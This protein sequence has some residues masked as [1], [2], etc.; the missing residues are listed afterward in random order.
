M[1]LSCLNKVQ[2]QPAAMVKW[3]LLRDDFSVCQEEIGVTSRIYSRLEGLLDWIVWLGSTDERFGWGFSG[4]E[5]TLTPSLPPFNGGLNSPYFV[6]H[7]YRS[8]YI[9]LPVSR[10][11]KILSLTFCLPADGSK[12]CVS[13]HSTLSGAA[14]FW[15]YWMLCCI[16][17]S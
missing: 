7:I 9:G 10:G 17:S 1:F 6:W 13:G 4:A 5:D 11:N 3:L 14:V 8:N 2:D 15:F 12:G 16:G